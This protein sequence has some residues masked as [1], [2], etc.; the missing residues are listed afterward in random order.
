MEIKMVFCVL[1]FVLW[2]EIKVKI[3]NCQDSINWWTLVFQPF[4]FSE[5]WEAKSNNEIK[6][7]YCVNS[8]L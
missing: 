1:G 7:V 3:V 6:M 4:G 8:V 5:E 2:T